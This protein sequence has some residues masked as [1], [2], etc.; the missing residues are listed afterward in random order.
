MSA[1]NDS[2]NDKPPKRDTTTAQQRPSAIVSNG[3][4]I[5]AAHQESEE[6]ARLRA[7]NIKLQ[8]ALTAVTDEN[9]IHAKLL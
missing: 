7:E 3:L 1:S 2:S 9:F 6:I 4:G 5:V 8:Q